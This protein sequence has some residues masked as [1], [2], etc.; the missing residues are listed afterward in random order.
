M[1]VRAGMEINLMHRSLEIAQFVNPEII[2]NCI[3]VNNE[4][5]KEFPTPFHGVAASRFL[6]YRVFFTC[7]DF[8]KTFS[9]KPSKNELIKYF[10]I[11]LNFSFKENC[12]KP[13]C[14]TKQK[15]IF[16]KIN[17]NFEFLLMYRQ[18]MRKF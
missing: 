6:F 8:S 4:N 1:K 9:N 5:L 10:F 17:K 2:L 15:K 3:L 11:F 7:I 14:T 12:A 18:N 13:F 16:S